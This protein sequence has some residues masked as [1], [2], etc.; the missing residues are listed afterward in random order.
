MLTK[1]Q[2]ITIRHWM[3]RNARPLDMARWQY[4]FEGG[5]PLVV[6]EALEAY[7]NEDGGF[8]HALEA[9]CW[10]PHSTPLQTWW[11]TQFLKET[12]MTDASHPIVQG[13]LNY[14]GSGDGT[15]DDGRWMF[16]VPENNNWPGAPWWSYAEGAPQPAY[17]PTASIVGYI[18]TS[19]H[20]DDVLRNKA[21]KMSE[22][23]IETFLKRE[24]QTDM[25]ELSCF[26]DLY[27][28]LESND[29][30]DENDD[31]A[32]KRQAEKVRC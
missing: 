2:Y 22:E 14:L 21:E 3:Y 6:L 29:K 31:S 27:Y 15:M 9:D 30:K 28:D 20:N 23:A 4:H 18:M 5:S 25:H 17:N 1:K 13:I 12:G 7:Q 26:I 19:G 16:S 32:F 8:G 11:A 24:E 10:N